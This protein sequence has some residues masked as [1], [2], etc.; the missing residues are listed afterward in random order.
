MASTH[1]SGYRS[2]MEMPSSFPDVLRNRTTT[3]CLSDRG[4]PRGSETPI[5]EMD[6]PGTKSS[7]LPTHE[8]K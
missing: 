6:A 8:W 1:C 5:Q 3:R 4:R 2:L 7:R